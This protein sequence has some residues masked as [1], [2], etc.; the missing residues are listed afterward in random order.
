LHF[1]YFFG[2]VPKKTSKRLKT[3]ITHQYKDF[4]EFLRAGGRARNI[5]P[6][7]IMG[8]V[9]VNYVSIN[10]GLMDEKIYRKH[11]F[12]EK[13]AYIKKKLYLCTKISPCKGE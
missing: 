9:R 12:K 8:K 4:L 11:F 13:L 2:G 3:Q 6:T 1:F 10:T 5:E 7:E